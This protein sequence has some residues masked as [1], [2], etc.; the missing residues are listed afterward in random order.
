MKKV[1]KHILVKEWYAKRKNGVF[2]IWE[3]Q[4]GERMETLTP[5]AKIP[6]VE[7]HLDKNYKMIIKGEKND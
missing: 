6:F 3:F 1:V 2:Q 7:Y 4:N 5:F